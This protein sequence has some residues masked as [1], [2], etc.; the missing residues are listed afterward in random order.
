M[1]PDFPKSRK[2]LSEKLRL[3][4]RLRVQDK[5]PW[6]VLGREFTQ[7]E[8]RAFSYEQII[9][10]SKRIVETGFEEMV[11]PIRVEF[12]DIPDLVGEALL[13]KLDEL[14]DDIA[15]QTSRLGQRRL[16]EATRLAGTAIDAG[17]QPFTQGLFLQSESAR[18]WEFDH[19]T[20]QQEGVY[21]A[22]PQTAERMHNLWQEWEK[23]SAFMKRVAELKAR[24]YEEWRDRE[25]RRKLV[26]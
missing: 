20:G 2:E 15:E 23:D 10:E 21:I 3:H 25:S 24:K 9:D 26:D 13:R 8:G 1:L 6:A 5:S 18:D 19:L 4:L 12:K 22:H 17:G 16:T 7:H 14:A 11:V